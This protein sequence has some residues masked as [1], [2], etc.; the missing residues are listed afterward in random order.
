MEMKQVDDDTISFS[1]SAYS[2]LRMYDKIMNFPGLNVECS[3]SREDLV[4]NFVEDPIQRFIIEQGC[5][6]VKDLSRY[7]VQFRLVR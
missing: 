4:P 5:N 6:M 2:M 7:T 3:T 1:G